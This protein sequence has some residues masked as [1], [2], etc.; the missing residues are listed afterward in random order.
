MTLRGWQASCIECQWSAHAVR[1]EHTEAAKQMYE[2]S[3]G[4]K[5]VAVY[6]VTEGDPTGRYSSDDLPPRA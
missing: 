2:Q 5:N 1:R 4:H 6:A 3:T